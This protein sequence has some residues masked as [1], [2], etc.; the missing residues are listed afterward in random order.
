LLLDAVVRV[1]PQNIKA[2]KTYLM[3]HQNQTDLDWLKDRILKTRELSETDKAKL[4]NYHLVL[5]K[6]LNGAMEVSARTEPFT[7]PLYEETET[8]DSLINATPQLELID[9][10]DYP[11]RI[12]NNEMR[13]KPRRRAIYNP[14]AFLVAGIFQVVSRIP[15]G[16]K[17]ALY[18]QQTV[19]QVKDLV[20]NPWDVYARLSKSPNFDKYS[21]VGLLLL[22]VLGLRLVTSNNFLGY[23]VLGLFVFGG[24]W[25]LIKFGNHN[26][27]NP[28]SQSRVY[29]HE[30]KVSLPEIKEINQEQKPGKEKSQKTIK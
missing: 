28:G 30:N 18:I 14:F 16:G 26:T 3:I 22:F 27:T 12:V 1:D 24:R 10:F 23:G 4:L 19:I 6:Q 20:K 2:W 8:T 15:L 21:E 17:L 29:L 13:T 5:T 25:W 7:F 9:M 11:T